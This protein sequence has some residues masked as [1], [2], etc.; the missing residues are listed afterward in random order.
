[1]IATRAIGPD[2]WRPWRELRLAALA[3]AP[4]SF[5]STLADWTGARDDE[6]RWRNRLATVPLNL[7]VTLEGEPVGMV[8]AT[9]PDAEGAVWLISMW[10]APRARGRGVGD[11][12]V[13]KVRDW[14][15]QIHP[16]SL[17]VLSVKSHNAHAIR[18]Y[19]RHGFVDVGPSPDDPG[20]RLMRLA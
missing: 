13:R 16:A 3:E 4:D 1:M 9:A 12:A 15:R 7:V 6:R 11:E 8:S 17:L 19:R 5:G 14:A 10:V 20:E 2:D 18:L